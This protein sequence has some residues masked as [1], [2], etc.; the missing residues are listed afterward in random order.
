MSKMGRRS[1]V[2]Q[3]W[4]P[5]EL[6]AQDTR[7]PRTLTLLNVE[8]VNGD[9]DAVVDKLGELQKN[10]R[11]VIVVKIV[12]NPRERSGSR[13]SKTPEAGALKTPANK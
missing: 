10:V 5:T 11:N 4:G 2:G 9:L 7:V 1:G 13:P 6:F 8:I 3:D 12:V